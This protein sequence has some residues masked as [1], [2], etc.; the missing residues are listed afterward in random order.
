M[1]VVMMMVVMSIAHT[2]ARRQSKGAILSAAGSRAIVAR[3]SMIAGESVIG[4]FVPVRSL[5]WMAR[6][7]C[8]GRVM[9]MCGTV[10]IAI[11]MAAMVMCD[12]VMS[13][14]VMTAAVTSAPVASWAMASA[15]MRIG[16]ACQ[17]RKKCGYDGGEHCGS[18]HGSAFRFEIFRSSTPLMD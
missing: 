11:M 6:R 5:L 8:A 15:A 1:V 2:A 13:T 16:N 17:R 10:M 14:A 9:V 18:G 3:E 4:P 7:V 12:A